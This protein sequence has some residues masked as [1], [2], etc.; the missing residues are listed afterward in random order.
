MQSTGQRQRWSCT[1]LAN[2]SAEPDFGH[3]QFWWVLKAHKDKRGSTA[4]RTAHRHEK[5]K[6]ITEH[7]F[8]KHFVLT[9][10]E[11]T[12]FSLLLVLVPTLSFLLC[13][14][15]SCAEFAQ[16]LHHLSPASISLRECVFLERENLYP[17]S[18]SPE[19][20]S[21]QQDINVSSRLS[22]TCTVKLSQCGI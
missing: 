14:G 3:K 17:A 10:A 16:T 13:R 6:G 11:S 1:V 4:L 20:N 2:V 7:T 21:P 18:Q 19:H 8:V 12:G 15:A 9:A 22:F 5:N